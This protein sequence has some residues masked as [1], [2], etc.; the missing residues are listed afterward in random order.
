MKEMGLEV[1]K[2]KYLSEHKKP[3]PRVYYRNYLWQQ[4]DQSSPNQVWVSDITYVKVGKAYYY[5]CVVMDLFSRMIISYGIS[6]A[7][8]STLTIST[9]GNAFIKR[10]KPKKLMFHSD[11]GSQ[12]TAYVF[13]QYLRSLK[14]KQSFSS[15]GNPYDNSVCESF[16]HT[17]KKEA[18]YHHLY[19]TPDQL[20]AV[21]EEYIHFYNEE[22]P[23]RKLNMKTPFQIETEYLLHAKNEKSQL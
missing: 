14:V 21:L 15:P 8:D 13:R 7:I 23:H 12:Y 11:Q 22:R 17:L 3:L 4:F 16:F 6:D 9:F 20:T 10:G 1:E 19:D 5:V 18:I 2:P